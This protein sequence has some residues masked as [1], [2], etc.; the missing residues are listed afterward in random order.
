MLAERLTPVQRSVNNRDMTEQ[1]NTTKTYRVTW[2]GSDDYRG[3]IAHYVERGTLLLV[4][5]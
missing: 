5:A 3:N 1:P 4:E 2:T